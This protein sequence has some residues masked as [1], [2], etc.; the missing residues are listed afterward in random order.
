[1]WFCC[2]S[3]VFFFTSKNKITNAKYIV[4]SGHVSAQTTAQARSL[5]GEEGG[6]KK[7]INS[8]TSSAKVNTASERDRCAGQSVHAELIV[9]YDRLYSNH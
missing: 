8:S 6:E 5:S 4:K 9:C 3:I 1:M 7:G 2:S